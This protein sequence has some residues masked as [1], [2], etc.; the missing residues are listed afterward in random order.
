MNQT[1]ASQT[2][3]SSKQSQIRF[4]PNSDFEKELRK[5]VQEYFNKTGLPKRDCP[6]MYFKTFLVLSWAILSYSL[7]VFANLP[8][9]GILLSTISLTMSLNGIG[10]NIMHDGV[11]GGYSNRPVI[12]KLMGLSMDLI[13]GSSYF[14]YWKHNYLH[15]SYPNITGHDDDI[16]AGIFARFS[17]HQ[18]RYFFHRY[19]HLYIW[20]LYGFLAIKWHLFD[21]FQSYYTKKIN[22]HHIKRPKCWD[23]IIFFGGKLCFFTIAFI[24]PSLFYPI[25]Y[26][27]LFYVLIA[28]LQGAK[29][30]IVLQL[31]H[32]NE[33]AEFPMHGSENEQK[34]ETTWIVHQLRTTS[35]FARNNRF[36]T[37]YVGGL[38]FQVEHHLF[39]KICHIN[40]PAISDIVAKT[41]VEYKVIYFSYDSFIAGLRSH[42]E[43]LRYLG[44][45]QTS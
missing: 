14:W 5:R 16:E 41:C 43:W 37:W 45:P 27:L 44:Q 9:W 32:C 29:M 15:H 40:Y 19:Q 17:P 31:A 12:N 8:L 3:I 33:E 11:H 1:I 28:F 36:L 7:L 2:P 39:P 13:G 22:G 20:F 38:N 26:V 18:K 21:D 24:I 6:K 42:Y 35:D 10:F 25:T 34:I 4:L 23:A 30:A